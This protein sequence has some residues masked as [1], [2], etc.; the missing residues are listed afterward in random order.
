MINN[1][2]KI[3]IIIEKDEAGYYAY[4]PELKG[5]FSQGDSFEEVNENIKEAI[6][7]YIETLTSQ[8]TQQFLT[9][10]IYTTS[11]EVSFAEIA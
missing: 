1:R 11:F 5:C 7:L 3:S 4:C 9:K 10:E 6:D 2:Y 8:E